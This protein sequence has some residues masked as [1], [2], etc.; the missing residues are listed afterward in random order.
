MIYLPDT[1]TWI[2]YLNPADSRIK[3]RL[4][5][6]RPE[7]IALCSV[8]KAELFY[9]AYRSSRREVN[10]HLLQVLFSRLPS[11]DFDDRAANYYGI[12]RADLASLGTPI[13]PNDLMIAAIA[14]VHDLVV[15][16]HN[17]REFGRVQGLRIEDWA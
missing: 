11:L 8:V 7:D 1:N 3:T 14:M 16:T 5:E 6:H 17:T 9:G 12:V 13:G 15:V 10:L 2:S 4:V